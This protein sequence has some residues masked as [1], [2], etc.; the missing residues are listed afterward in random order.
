MCKL[1]QWCFLVIKLQCDEMSYMKCSAC[2]IGNCPTKYIFRPRKY[3][4]LTAPKTNKPLTPWHPP[5]DTQWHTAAVSWVCWRSARKTCTYLMRTARPSR[6]RRRV[7]W[8][9]TCTSHASAAAWASSCLRRCS[10]IN[11]TIPPKWPSIGH[12]TSWLGFL[13]NTTVRSIIGYTRLCKHC[14]FT[15][16]LSDWFFFLVCVGLTRTIPQMNNFVVYDTFFEPNKA[17]TPEEVAKAEERRVNITNRYEI[18]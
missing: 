13:V 11:N 8:T 1:E 9:F 2:K 3:Y 12:L 7:C 4:A 17:L 18:T 10:P 14:W 6:C 16:S 5:H 15:L